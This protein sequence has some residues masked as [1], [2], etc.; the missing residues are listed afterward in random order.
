M[1]IFNQIAAVYDRMNHVMSLG[2]DKR[3]R[4]LAC[5]AVDMEPLRILDLATGTGD[6]ALALRKR[7]PQAEIIG[8]DSSAGMLESAREKAKTA[9]IKFIEGD[10]H[11]IAQSVE[12][13]VDLI[14][15]A[16]GF[17]NFSDQRLALR[18][19]A[20]I[21]KPDG[22]LVVL[23]FF[24]PGSRFLGRMVNLWIS[25]IAFVFAH[26]NRDAYR[27]LTNSI[28]GAKTELEFRQLASSVGFIAVS[29]HWYSP[30]CTRLEFCKDAS[31]GRK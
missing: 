12:V 24:R 18:E 28:S 25:F 16:F 7:F 8:L 29:R 9:N 11:K 21:L 14:T 27:Y 22:R 31:G 4:E 26:S 2:R 3:W 19:C 5:K 6:L 20:Q 17:R 13:S 10:A 30:S 15:C 1:K 23:E